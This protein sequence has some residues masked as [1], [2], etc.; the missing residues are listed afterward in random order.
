VDAQERQ[1]YEE[2]MG[3]YLRDEAQSE[4]AKATRGGKDLP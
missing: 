1:H 3:R 2:I 4:V